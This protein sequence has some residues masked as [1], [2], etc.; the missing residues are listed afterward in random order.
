MQDKAKLISLVESTNN[1]ANKSKLLNLFTEGADS[2]YKVSI[3]SASI[4]QLVNGLNQTQRDN[5]I[6][7]MFGDYYKDTYETLTRTTLAD[8]TTSV[9]TRKLVFIGTRFKSYPALAS[10]ASYGI[11]GAST[12]D[13]VPENYE[14]LDTKY[15]N[16]LLFGSKADYDLFISVLN[17]NDSYETAPTQEQK[18]AVRVAIFNYYINYMFTFKYT[19]AMY[20]SEYDIIIKGHPSETIEGYT[21]WNNHYV[22]SDF[23]YNK[24]VSNLMVAFHNQ[25]SIGKYISMIPYGTAA[26]NLAYLGLGDNLSIGGLNSSTYTGYEQSVDVVFVMQNV[27]TA[28]NAN[29]N[30]LG[31]YNEGSLVYHKDGKEMVTD[32]INNG[33]MYK[34]LYEYF[35]AN[36]QTAYADQYRVLYENW[37]RSQCNLEESDSLEGYG[38]DAQGFL[39]TPQNA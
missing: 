30:L 20:G 12:V 27:N 39:I 8:D 38:V 11:G 24:L 26:E 32:F 21:T 1:G 15:K 28:I 37:L 16:P 5:Y 14:Q 35:K 17:N 7:L 22:A 18:D 4:S 25:D 31:R 9:P 29:A 2:N 13:D 23:N 33:N 19:Y 34:S 36:S 10:N 3:R 6:K